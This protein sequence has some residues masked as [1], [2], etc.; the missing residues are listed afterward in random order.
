MLR[1]SETYTDVHSHLLWGADNGAVTEEDSLAMVLEAEK[2]GIDTIIATPHFSAEIDS[3]SEFVKRREIAYVSLMKTLMQKGIKMNIIKGAEVHLEKDTP[4]LAEL[5]RLAFGGTNKILIELPY[6]YWGD[7]VYEALEAIE[8][9]GFCPIIAHVDRYPSAY[10]E[11]IYGTGFLLQAD[12][13]ALAK[14]QGAKEF[15]DRIKNGSLV[16][17]GSNA[18]APGDGGYR[19]FKKAMKNLL[20]FKADF[21]KR[22]E[23]ILKGENTWKI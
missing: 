5:E 13:G 19:D 17:L 10:T 18:H 7:W 8:G 1:K 6:T 14:K 15:S 21:A 2:A 4:R 20:S 23:N 12:A 22:T 11:K 3:I 16:F 9:R